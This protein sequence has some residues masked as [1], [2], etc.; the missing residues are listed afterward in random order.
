MFFSQEAAEKALNNEPSLEIVLH[1]SDAATMTDSLG[2][3]DAVEIR[4][5]EVKKWRDHVQLKSFIQQVFF[6]RI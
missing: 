2:V 4:D 6:I 3:P 1:I 5:N